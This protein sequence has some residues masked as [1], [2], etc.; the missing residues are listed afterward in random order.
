MWDIGIEDEPGG[1]NYA[2]I[3]AARIKA[4]NQKLL[5]DKN[6]KQMTASVRAALDAKALAARR[7]KKQKS[8]A[9]VMRAAKRAQKRA[10]RKLK[11]KLA[12]KLRR[13]KKRWSKMSPKKRE[14]MK[15]KI[16]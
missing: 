1:R 8:L 2:A 4:R 9:F 11:R 5:D 12:K 6:N 14:K 7:P 16:F 10:A 13:M 15:K 3:Q